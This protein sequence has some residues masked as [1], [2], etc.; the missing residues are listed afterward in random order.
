[1]NYV[2]ISRAQKVAKY[3]LIAAVLIVSF[4]LSFTSK[5]IFQLNRKDRIISKKSNW[6]ENNVSTVQPKKCNT[7]SVGVDTILLLISI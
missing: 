1:M 4:H 6:V 3:T 7:K 5:D 2:Y